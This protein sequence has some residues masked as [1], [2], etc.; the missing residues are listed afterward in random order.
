MASSSTAGLTNAKRDNEIGGKNPINEDAP[1]WFGFK[2]LFND[3]Q[4][5]E[6]HIAISD[7]DHPLYGATT[8]QVSVIR[9]NGI[10]EWYTQNSHE[11][12]VA[13]VYSPHHTSEEA[14]NTVMS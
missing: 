14:G 8:E 3:S 12:R 2:S 11:D 6:D 7:S 5:S 10:K 1:V 4:P 13:R 9:D